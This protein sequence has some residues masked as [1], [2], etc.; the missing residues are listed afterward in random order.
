M[1]EFYNDFILFKDL[2][3]LLKKDLASF[4]QRFPGIVLIPI[5]TSKTSF[6]ISIVYL[7]DVA[8]ITKFGSRNSLVQMLTN[9]AQLCEGMDKLSA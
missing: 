5:F 2:R 6:M 4:Q 9:R 8:P 1:V 7:K 3:S